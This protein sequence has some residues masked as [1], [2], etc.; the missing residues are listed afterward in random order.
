MAFS[1]TQRDKE[2][3]AGV[4][5]PRPSSRTLLLMPL[6]LPSEPADQQSAA[7]HQDPRDEQR[8]SHAAA[9]AGEYTPYPAGNTAG[10]STAAAAGTT[11]A[12]TAA[13]GTAVVRATVIVRTAVVFGTAVAVR[14]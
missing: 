10:G 11:A 1:G 2:K 8:Q 9:R 7:R 12:G 14:R 13:T 3:R 5:E 6:P 4:W